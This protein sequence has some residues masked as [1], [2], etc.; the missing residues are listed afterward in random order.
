MIN[1]VPTMNGERSCSSAARSNKTAGN[2]SRNRGDD[3]EP[4]ELA[5]LAEQGDR[6]RLG[7]R[8]AASPPLIPKT[9]LIISSQ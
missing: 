2:P 7:G 5:V 6:P 1:A 4:E 3:K 8:S 9:I